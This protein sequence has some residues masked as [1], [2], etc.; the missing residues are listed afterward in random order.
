MKARSL[1]NFRAFLLTLLESIDHP[2][3]KSFYPLV[4]ENRWTE[5]VD[6]ADAALL[7][8]YRAA[9]EHRLVHQLAAVIR[10]Y[11]Y[12]KGS[13][14]CDPKG[15]ALKLFLTSEHRC[16]L[17]NRRFSLYE[18]C[19][20][21]HEKALVMARSWISHTL[22]DLRLPEI[23]DGCSFGPGASVG[24]AGNATNMARKLLSNVWTVTPGAY[25]YAR[26][27]LIGDFLAMELLNTAPGRQQFSLDHELFN[28]K[29][30]DKTSLI[31][32]NK[33]TFVPKT[34]KI[35]RTIAV[36]PLLNGFVQKGVDLFMRKRLKRV[37][38]DLND[39]TRNQILARKGSERG[40][41]DP[42]VTI[43]LSSASDSISIGLC[44]Y[45]LPPE[46]FDFLSQIR[47]R[48]YMLNGNIS[49]YH[50]FTTMGNGFCFPLETLLFASICHTAYSEKSLKDDFSVYGDDIIVRQSV[51]TR[52]LDLLRIC[53]FQV[54]SNKT[55]LFGPF[56]ESCG[57]D[58]FEGED[59]R[60][61]NLDYA[62]DSLQNIIKF[63]NL[64]RSKGTWEGIFYQSLQY[65]ESLIPSELF[66]CRPFTGQVD[67]ALEVPLDV[68]M[69]SSF[70][71]F[72][73]FYQTW[74]WVELIT[75]A[76]PDVLVKRVAGYNVA[77]M[78]G[79][80]TGCR[81]QVPFAERRNTRTKIRRIAY[82]GASST[83]LPRF[84]GL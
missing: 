10:K 20:S 9:D 46:W 79:A 71:R 39:Q 25:Y 64:A 33:L 30:K 34:A 7:T 53:G 14:A 3:S 22:G 78:R 32:Y 81:S 56:R 82:C 69:A 58:W 37:G 61:L 73:K 52:V 68:F 75:S 26:S 8:E 63:C 48:C 35:D 40:E 66:F 43:D 57:A 12:P 84:A 77:L 51:A 62:F 23:W 5:L 45:M 21:P 59:V 49:V 47:S 74:S 29:F 31:D 50:K 28:Q 42:Y 24:V 83:F 55:C 27:A 41:S 19:R 36:E 38:I 76:R 15:K 2:I 80:V 54:N 60:P 6:L 17:V 11:P 1:E 16:S 18:K 65:L 70:S 13:V 67:T 44:R 4:F 72:D